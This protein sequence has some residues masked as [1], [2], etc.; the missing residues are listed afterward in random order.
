VLIEILA[1]LRIA[2]YVKIA[3]G[4]ATTVQQSIGG[5]ALLVTQPFG[6]LAR[7]TKLDDVTHPE[8]G[9]RACEG[10]QSMIRLWT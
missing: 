10:V 4:L 5:R 9:H 1:G 2:R 6:L 3:L 8:L 7:R